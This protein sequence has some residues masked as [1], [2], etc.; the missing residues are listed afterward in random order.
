MTIV[1]SPQTPS[2]TIPTVPNRF[3]GGNLLVRALKD[4]GVQQIFS[5]SGGPLNSIYHA[6]AV[7]GMP[8]RHTRHEAG[9]CFMAEAGNSPSAS[10]AIAP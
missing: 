9:A 4:L 3:E 1:R 2:P 10:L 8:L 7:E 6:C 5:V